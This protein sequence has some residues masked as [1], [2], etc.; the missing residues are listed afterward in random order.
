MA[1]ERKKLMIVKKVNI[2]LKRCKQTAALYIVYIIIGDGA[3]EPYSAGFEYKEPLDEKSDVKIGMEW[4][5]IHVK[6]AG[7]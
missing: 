6:E 1:K 2:F 5:L 7:S 3:M 4:Q